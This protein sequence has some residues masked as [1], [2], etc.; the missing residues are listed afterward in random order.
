MGSK[1]ATKAEM[2]RVRVAL[3]IAYPGVF[4]APQSKEPRKPLALGIRSKLYSE[5]RFMFPEISL[6]LIRGGL[7][8]YTN[9]FKYLLACKAGTPRIGL[10]GEP[11]GFVTKE[12]AAYARAKLRSVKA[13]H[14][15]GR[16]AVPV[17]EAAHV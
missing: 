12:Q 8:D 15:A 5:A 7:Y 1:K 9:G 14:K 17:A 6:R 3:S 16:K 11:D 4:A 10:D 13:R 2:H